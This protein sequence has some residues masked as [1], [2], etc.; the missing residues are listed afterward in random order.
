MITV[1]MLNDS[2]LSWME[3]RV[4]EYSDSQRTPT[5]PVA[6][7]IHQNLPYKEG[8]A[9]AVTQSGFA[10]VDA[11]DD[12]FDRGIGNSN[13]EVIQ[14]LADWIY[15][16]IQRS[17]THLCLIDE[18]LSSPTDASWQNDM[19]KRFAKAVLFSDNSIFYCISQENCDK[20]F[21]FDLV[22]S[23]YWFFFCCLLVN[24]HN[25]VLS[26]CPVEA[27]VNPHQIKRAVSDVR[28]LVLNA[29]DLEGLMIWTRHDEL[30]TL[31]QPSGKGIL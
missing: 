29:F 31:S 24:D 15:D 23:T 11:Y 9:I 30:L 13:N 22:N 3:A 28:G 8:K 21:V 19:R 2:A 6:I 17:P 7:S 20:D 12:G 25:K 18:Q 5:M 4:A 27:T 14:A 16:F 1:D 10:S 26:G